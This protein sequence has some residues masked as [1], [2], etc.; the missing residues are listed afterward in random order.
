M[1]GLVLQGNGTGW[2]PVPLLARTFAEVSVYLVLWPAYT[3][4]T[5]LKRMCVQ[6]NYETQFFDNGFTPL[7]SGFDGW[8]SNSGSGARLPP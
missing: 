6:V 4:I 3:G 5:S 8:R 7:V 1:S 2:K